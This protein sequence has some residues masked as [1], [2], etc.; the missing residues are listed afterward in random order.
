VTANKEIIKQKLSSYFSNIFDKELIEE[1]SSLGTFKSLPSG[2]VIINIGDKLIQIPFI[3]NGAIKII[4]K[5]QKGKEIKLYFLRKGDTCG[6]SFINCINKRKSIVK[7]ITE[8]KTEVIFLPANEI[9][10]WL[11]K[12]ESWRNYIIESY[13][14]RQIKMIETVESLTFMKLEDRLY[15]FLLDE[16]KIM[17]DS[18]LTITHQEIA[19][20]L[21]TSRV[22]ISRSLKQLEKEA[23]I[24]IRRNKII[25]NVD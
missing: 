3:L 7:A 10:K 23:K 18:V 17:N 4:R 14:M 2:E 5:D 15:K 25:V 13:H 6:I 1:I 8:N 12:Y 9:C 21:N 20:N 24:T 19:E 11:K 16:V 22:V